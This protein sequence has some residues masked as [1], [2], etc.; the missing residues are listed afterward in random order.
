MAPAKER[1]GLPFGIGVWVDYAY[2]I[3]CSEVSVAARNISAFQRWLVNMDRIVPVAA[4][5]LATGWVSAEKA[6]RIDK[7]TSLEI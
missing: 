3:T 5:G 6:G 4:T 7:S 2:A 1:A